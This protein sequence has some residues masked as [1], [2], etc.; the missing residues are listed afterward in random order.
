MKGNSNNG[1]IIEDEESPACKPSFVIPRF[2]DGSFY[3][4]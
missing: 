1:Q 4:Y 3:L 2:P